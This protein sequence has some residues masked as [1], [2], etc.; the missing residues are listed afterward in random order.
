MNTVKKVRDF[1][2]GVVGTIDRYVASKSINYKIV[3][4]DADHDSLGWGIQDESGLTQYICLYR[5][6]N[7][8]FIKVST[9]LCSFSGQELDQIIWENLKLALPFRS[10]I[11]EQKQI[12][13]LYWT[14]IDE[15]SPEYLSWVLEKHLTYCSQL[16]Q[17]IER[18]YGHN[19]QSIE[20]DIDGSF[21]SKVKVRFPEIY[22][23]MERFAILSRNSYEVRTH[24]DEQIRIFGWGL[25]NQDITFLFWFY[26]DEDGEIFIH[27]RSEIC[28]YSEASIKMVL[29]ENLISDLPFRLAITDEKVIASTFSAN[30]QRLSPE[31]LMWL[32]ESQI[33]YTKEKQQIIKKNSI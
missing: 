1:Y 7:E 3:T 30:V 28:S 24:E 2:P 23:A 19:I 21:V 22:K 4:E 33:T 10:S 26:E 29:R 8:G 6:K 18:R 9:D 5:H 17:Y 16:K 31:F 11:D 27:L 25:F 20:S 12:V 15:I 13:T 32:L 14:K